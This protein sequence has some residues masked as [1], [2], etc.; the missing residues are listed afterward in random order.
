MVA[1]AALCQP[2]MSTSCARSAE[3]AAPA[4]TA[5]QQ[6]RER[7][8]NL[9]DSAA[10]AFGHHDDPVYGHTWC[11]DTG[12]SDVLETAG[13]YPAAMSWDMGMIELADSANLDG[14]S[15]D[16]MR[17]EVAAQDLRG[18]FNV[19]SWHV[20]NPA[21]PSTDSWFLADT[22]IV[23]QILNDSIVGS[24]FDNWTTN[25]AQFFNSLRRADGSKIGV[26]FRPWHEHTGSWFWWGAKL[27]TPDDYKAL[28]HRTR[29]IFD[30]EGVD[31]VLWAYSP[32]R[33][34]D[35]QQ[36]MERYPGDEY[37]DIMGAD[38]YHFGGEKGLPTYRRDASRTLAVAR[39]VA[40]ERGKLAA[41]S[42]TGSET[43]PMAGWWTEVLL[44]I[45][46]ENPV[47]YVVVWRNAHD[48]PTHYYAPFA[49]EAS[50]ESFKNFHDSPKVVFAGGM[51]KF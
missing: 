39:K 1:A 22:T 4:T 8:A 48:K 51:S 30:R 24:R 19:F 17:D 44:P 35:E 16:R 46:E 49:G 38:V 10:V 28:W 27:C 18:G 25:L 13:E 15:F 36:Y 41:F 5:A 40:A 23:S 14:V 32:D 11:G 34:A 20:R 9:T 7:L 12:R 42:E 26:V 50:V 3:A 47:S 29:E 21:D 45:L 2:I 6:L 37:V 31:N 43:L 33:V